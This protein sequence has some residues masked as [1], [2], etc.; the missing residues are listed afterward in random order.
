[1]CE[2]DLKVPQCEI[3]HNSDFHDFY[4]VISLWGWGAFLGLK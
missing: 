2:K 4:T 1:M 3:F